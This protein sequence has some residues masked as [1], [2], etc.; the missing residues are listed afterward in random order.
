MALIFIRQKAIDKIE[1]SYLSKSIKEIRLS[2]NQHLSFNFKI[3]KFWLKVSKDLFTKS[4][5]RIRYRFVDRHK[6]T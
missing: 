2:L 1:L 6:M 5:N 3:I 4:N